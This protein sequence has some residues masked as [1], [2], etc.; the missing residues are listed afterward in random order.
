MIMHLLS[1]GRQFKSSH[2]GKAFAAVGDLVF[3][4]IWRIIN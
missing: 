4:D 3:V 1:T 2:W